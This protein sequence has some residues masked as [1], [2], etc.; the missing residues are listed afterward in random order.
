MNWTSS[1][2]IYRTL[3]YREHQSNVHLMS[4]CYLNCGFNLCFVTFNEFFRLWLV[5]DIIVDLLFIASNK[6]P[7]VISHHYIVVLRLYVFHFF[8]SFYSFQE[9]VEILNWVAHEIGRV[10]TYSVVGLQ[11]W[12]NG[13]W[14]V[15]MK[16]KTSSSLQ[17]LQ[18]LFDDIFSLL[19]CVPKSHPLWYQWGS[20]IVLLAAS[21]PLQNF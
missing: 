8:K 1:F 20:L 6:F 15:C 13:K 14:E 4:H 3:S 21:R 19:I 9:F 16:R 7:F 10:L 11:I 2:M 17:L 12:S 5:L 18:K